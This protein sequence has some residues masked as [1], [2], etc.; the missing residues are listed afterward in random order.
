MALQVEDGPKPATK[1]RSG[2]RSK[3]HK[4]PPSDP[5]GP[6]SPA[7][8]WDSGGAPE[9]QMHPQAQYASSQQHYPLDTYPSTAYGQVHANSRTGLLV[10]VAA[11]RHC[12]TSCLQLYADWL[13]SGVAHGQHVALGPGAEQQLRGPASVG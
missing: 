1:A 7:A 13:H 3:A 6:S 8:S 5:A 12:T 9:P 11:C 10:G 4:A 2:R